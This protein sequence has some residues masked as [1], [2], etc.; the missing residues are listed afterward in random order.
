MSEPIVA[1][2]RSSGF[3]PSIVLE[4]KGDTISSLVDAINKLIEK[5]GEVPHMEYIAISDKKGWVRIMFRK[6]FQYPPVVIATS[7]GYRIRM[8]MLRELPRVKLKRLSM[9]Q[10]S[11]PRVSLPRI[12]KSKLPKWERPDFA[13]QLALDLQQKF[14]EIAGN[15]GP[16]NYLKDQFSF[17][18]F[19]MGLVIGGF[20]NWIYDMYIGAPARKWN[21]FI[22][23]FANTT[24][25]MVENA[26]N[27]LRSSIERL[28]A[29]LK[30]TLEDVVNHTNE[31]IEFIEEQWNNVFVENFNKLIKSVRE[32]WLKFVS[33]YAATVLP[34]KEVTTMYADVYVPDERI[35][36]NVFAIGF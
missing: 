28:N 24:N 10:Y 19:G 26:E 12:D 35:R 9:P 7:T 17:I 15:W 30:S 29:M 36:V 34:V 8:P 3:V 5:L 6:P 1:V 11:L 27:E 14:L 4:E 2:V 31:N 21:K 20:L 22:E 32:E 18:F 13:A 25:S 23:N 33:T 16:L